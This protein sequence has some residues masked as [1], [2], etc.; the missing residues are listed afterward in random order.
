MQPVADNRPAD[1]PSVWIRIFAQ[2]LALMRPELS[3]EESIRTAIAE[4]ERLGHLQ[5]EQA[6]ALH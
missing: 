6:V 5:P 4:F 3:A 1:P 2:R